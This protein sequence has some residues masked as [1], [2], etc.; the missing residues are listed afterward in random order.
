VAEPRASGVQRA[1]EPS[2]AAV[3][4]DFQQF[5]DAEH[6][7]L[8]GA[9]CLVTGNRH[10][11]EELMQEAFLKVWERWDVVQGMESPVGYLYRTAMNAFRMRFRRAKIAA[12]RVARTIARTDPLDVFEARFELD[13]GLA[14]LTNRQRAAV[15]LTDLL[16]FS[17]AD[18][19]QTLGTTA[20]TVRKL[21]SEGRKK[22]RAELGGDDG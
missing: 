9:L 11:A 16:E 7:R 6:G 3:P 22:L 14:A 10:D 2:H 21:A 13:R 4:P 1:S 17:S 8:F 15:V 18:A 20:A 12:R 19:A 5:Y